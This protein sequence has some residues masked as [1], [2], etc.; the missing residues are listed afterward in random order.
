MV[1]F[2]K[3]I[4]SN[5]ISFL[6]YTH[7]NQHK[8][9]LNILFTEFYLLFRRWDLIN[10]Y[11]SDFSYLNLEDI[12]SSY[13]PLKA[14][15]FFVTKNL[16]ETRQ[17]M[18]NHACLIAD[19]IGLPSKPRLVGQFTFLNSLKYY[20]RDRYFLFFS[21]Y[22]YREIVYLDYINISII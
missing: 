13:L 15:S 22:H 4:F 21:H 16:P 17:Y 12:S 19:S 2:P 10:R 9:K 14:K 18:F 5:I 7:L 20:L 6:D 3:E 1:L 11:P 8:F